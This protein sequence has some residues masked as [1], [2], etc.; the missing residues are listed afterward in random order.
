[1]VDQVLAVQV[2]EPGQPAKRFGLADLPIVFGGTDADVVIPGYRGRVELG[3]LDG[4]FYIQ[5]G[6]V[7]AGARINDVLVQGSVWLSDGDTIA[8][9]S[10]RVTCRLGSAGL[11]LSIVH[12]ETAGD[13]APPEAEGAHEDDEEIVPIV[14]RPKSTAPEQAQRRISRG[15][16]IIAGLCTLLAISGWFAFTA[17]SVAIRFEP[18]ADEI[19]LP[20]TLLK[21]RLGDRF[22]LR[23]G[24]HRLM[25]EKAGYHSFATRISVG[26]DADQV[27][28]FE[29]TKLPGQVAITVSPE[30]AATVTVDGE[31]LGTTPLTAELAAG[32]HDI[33]LSA[34]RFIE[35]RQTLEV[36]GGGTDESLDVSLTPNWAPVELVTTPPGADVTVDGV[37]IGQTPLVMELEQGDREIEATLSGYNAWRDVVSVV[38]NE[39]QTLPAVE[40]AQADGRVR[41]VSEPSGAAIAVNGRY[42]GE[43]PMTIKLRPGRGHTITLTKPGY[44]AVSRELSVAADSGRQLNVSLIAEVGE[45][46]VA[47]TPSDAEIFVDGERRGIG[48]QKLTLTAVSHRIEGRAEGHQPAAATVTPKPGFPQEIQLALE[49]FA[50]TVVGRFPKTIVTSIGNKL[51]LVRSGNF[52]MGSSRREQGRRSNEVLRQVSLTKPF[53]LGVQ[54]VTNR[55]FRMFQPEH[56]SGELGGESLD[57]DEQ[58]VVNVTWEQAAEFCNWLSIK[59]GLQPVYEASGD[60]YVAVRPLRNGYRL[61][62]EAEWV[63]AGR[64]A[65]GSAPLRFPWGESLPP[66]DRT[67]N[68]ADVSARNIFATTLLTYGDGYPV[69]APVGQFKANPI[70]LFDIGGNVA[71]WMQDYYHVTPARSGEP[72]KDP[73]GPDKGRYHVL[74][75]PSFRSA[76]LTELRMAHRDYSAESKPDVGFRIARNSE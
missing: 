68:F 42:Q 59:D 51:T 58:P 47:V 64:Y 75:G 66:P 61:P 57:G 30:V 50:E 20:G 19:S 49:P 33:M 28:E 55:E 26:S 69:S 41:L 63:W 67:G 34:P 1:M 22:L 3:A 43:T 18:A 24:E 62:T 23:Q 56:R 25:A 35:H 4:R 2:L 76:T 65:E 36:E 29:L 31:P 21:L 7:S 5:A 27:V 6:R 9:A 16:L 39:A 52:V 60:T 37:A 48:S 14:F 45:V 15:N 53:Y 17:K 46:S 32:T 38:A 54:E 12:G 10:T 70:G 73:L 13:T 40:L 11:D 72:E 71:E 8:L 74:R 44:K